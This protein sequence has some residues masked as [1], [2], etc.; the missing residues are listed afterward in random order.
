MLKY[1]LCSFPQKFATTYS[2]NSLKQVL[3]QLLPEDE[4]SDIPFVMNGQLSI[5]ERSINA[6]CVNFENFIAEKG[7]Y[8][9]NG[10]T[11]GNLI[12][13]KQNIWKISH[14]ALNEAENQ[15]AL[16]KQVV[17][18]GWGDDNKQG[19]DGPMS[20]KWTRKK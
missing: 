20:I 9:K 7:F 1:F 17:L 3:I 8:A 10:E 15:K 13:L 12:A 11:K 16:E 18:V 6:D 19:R 5:I 2:Y 14:G 4:I